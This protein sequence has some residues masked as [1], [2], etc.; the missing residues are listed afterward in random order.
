MKQNVKQK[1]QNYSV[2]NSTAVLTKPQKTDL[3][4]WLSKGF[5]NVI[6]HW[7]LFAIMIPAILFYIFFMYRPMWGL[8]I[9]F[10]NF[11]IFAGIDKSPWVGFDHFVK[12]VES[13]YFWRNLKNTLLINF[14]GLI[15]GF[16]IPILL[17]LMLNEVKHVRYKKLIQTLTYLP[18]FISIVVIAGIVVNFLS[19]SNGLIN[20]MIEKLGGQKINFLVKP[21]YFRTIFISMNIWKEAGFNA[22]VYLAALSGID[23]NLYE[24]AYVDGANKFKRILHVTIPG[25]M[26]TIIVLLVLKIGS[27][28]SVGY[29]AIILLYQPATFE[30]ADVISTYVYRM[31]LENSRYD[32]AAAVGLF[33]A[34]VSVILVIFANKVSKKFSGTSLW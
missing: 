19:P 21:E 34:I 12:F 17:A 8:Q 29:E 23:P 1:K 33:N 31:G 22:I 15:F 16:P 18:H 6:K 14:Y 28:L 2:G 3:V 7:Q 27:M 30:T 5:K 25:I 11:K 32:Y 10:K 13:P 9:A 20:I 26:P 24:A 4:L